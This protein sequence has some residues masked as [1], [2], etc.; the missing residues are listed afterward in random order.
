MPQLIFHN[1]FSIQVKLKEK[2]KTKI[3]LENIF[4]YLIIIFGY[5]CNWEIVGIVIKYYTQYVSIKY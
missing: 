4:F 5:P 3:T 2:K 1:S